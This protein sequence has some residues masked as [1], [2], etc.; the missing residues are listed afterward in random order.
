MHRKSL[1]VLLACGLIAML[2]YACTM[3]TAQ[4]LSLDQARLA[5]EFTQSTPQGWINSKPLRWSDLQGKVVLVDFWAFDCWNCYNS[6]PWLH[7]LEQR[8]A[9]KDLRIVSVHTPELSQERVRANVEKKVREY[10]LTNPVM[11]DNDYAYWNAMH[12]QYWPAFYLVDRHGLV[13]AAY[14]GETHAGDGNA[15]QIE[16]AINELL[17]EEN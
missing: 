15:R 3:Q 16:Q 10:A 17:A 14:V 8:Y 2:G 12:N 9:G 7:S 11:L 6:I 5:P 13:R 1:A 4:A